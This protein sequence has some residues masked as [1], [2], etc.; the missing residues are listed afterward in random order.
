M[1][2]I[3]A[4]AWVVLGSPGS[5][6]ARGVVL[7][8]GPGGEPVLVVVQAGD[9]AATIG[10]RLAAADVI[11]SA[12]SFRLL[13]RLTGAE[14]HLAAGEYEFAP[15][16]AALDGLARIRGGLTSARVVT[17]PEG[18]RIE[19]VA[20]LLERRGIVTAADFLAAAKA[21]APVNS[22]PGSTLIAGRPAGASLEGYL[23]PAT[24][25]FPHSVSAQQVVSM[26]VK[27]LD[28]RLTPDLIEQARRENLSVHQVLTLA[29]IIE[30]EAVVPDERPLIASVYLNR[31]RQDLPLQADPTV[32]YAVASLPGGVNQFGYWKRE[33]SA[34]D[35][36]FDSPYNTYTRKGLPPGPIAN[37]GIDAIIAVIQPAKTEYLYFAARPDGR[38]A[39]ST[40]FEEHQRNVAKYLR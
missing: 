16:T 2:L 6:P 13:A 30:R 24:Y 31:L 38:H 22:G 21:L 18:L 40:T 23:Y 15:G 7:S 32:Q 26:M 37:P 35:L 1:A 25:S 9:T 39:F 33:L 5:V 11:D 20:A 12:R 36:Q 4:A 28:D 29:S 27:A 3:V 17:I 19:E 14:R 34:Q 8:P 10:D